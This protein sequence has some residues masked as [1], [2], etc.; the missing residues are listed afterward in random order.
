MEIARG[1][2]EEWSFPYYPSHLDHILITDE[3]FE[4]FAKPSARVQTIRIEDALPR[5]SDE[6]WIYLS[7]HRPVGLQIEL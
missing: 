5:G 2:P 4:A 7:D 1:D 3:L 6:Y